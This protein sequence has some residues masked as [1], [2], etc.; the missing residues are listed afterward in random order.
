[1]SP[2]PL[3]RPERSAHAAIH[4]Y[5]YQ[6]CLGV[7]RWLDL[8]DD[9]TLVVEGD[10]DLDR[11]LRDGTAVSEQVKAYEGRLGVGDRA[12]R[13][14]LRAFALAYAA[15]RQDGRDRRF[16]FT[17][18]AEKRRPRRRD[19]LDVIAAWDD[20]HR[21]D[22]VVAELRRILP[23]EDG[24]KKKDG[25]KKGK[26]KDGL[27]VADALA[28]LDAAPGRW[29]SFVAAVE[30]RFDEPKLDGIRVRIEDVLR[31]RGFHP[32]AHVDRLVAH[33]LDASTRPDVAER[34]LTA[35]DLTALLKTTDE[36]LARWAATP[37]AVHLRTVFDEVAELGRLLH[38][39]TR[40]LPADPSP[41]HLLTAAHEVV[42]FH[43]AGRHDEL[44]ALAAWCDADAPAG[45][46]LWTGEGG[47]GKTRLLIEWCRQLRG[48]GWHAGFLHR[49]LEDGVGRLAAGKVP[50]LV[51]VDYA[52]TRQDVV[53]P[54][55]YKV[56]TA[57]GGPRCRVVLL[58]RREA[59]WWRILR[60]DDAHVAQ[61]IDGSPE[62]RRLEALGSG[63][64]EAFGEAVKA[65]SADD[66]DGVGVPNLE[67]KGLDR[68]L[69]IHM[70]ALAS[71]EG[72]RVEDAGDAL[73]ETL[74]HERYFWTRRADV[75]VQEEA[76]RHLLR[77]GV[78]RAVAALTL[79]GGATGEGV[80]R[81]LNAATEGLALKEDVRATLD[82][83]VL[84]PLYGDGVRLGGLEPDLL[85]EELVS[86]CLGEEPALLDRVLAVADG[87]GRASTL[88]VLTRLAGRRPEEE[89]WLRQAFAGHVE[90]LAEV[91]LTVA[92]EIGDPVGRV[93][94]DFVGGVSGDLA[95][96]LM[97]R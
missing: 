52:E 73:R 54:L 13:D 15:L 56:A 61:L 6:T 18:T 90:E 40:V 34:C 33:L 9:E 50:R 42:P 80:S 28:W 17:T 67:R 27:T 55:L 65:F 19:D 70:A 93:L 5:L 36:D 59:D 10:E 60:E 24:K 22:D 16:V 12:L 45:V 92:V 58:A 53:K 29:Q 7:L 91:A 85:G 48:Q 68:V 44:A 71:V 32:S 57:E 51:V 89:R 20:P 79:T 41:G 30:M 64:A 95:E 69:Y 49:H 77:K 47:T 74:V 2:A 66:G 1:M 26:K 35:Q 83:L 21:R 94:A 31:K 14:S 4:G 87:D 37:R 46:W 84:R 82:E 38:D 62:V 97:N 8:G 86:S 75:F 25:K 88:T 81:L 63:R 76:Q 78:P 96:R 11:L 23:E 72:K 43:A 39:G 3:L